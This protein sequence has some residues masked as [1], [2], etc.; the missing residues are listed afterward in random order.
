MDGRIGMM[1]GGWFVSEK[2][3]GDKYS[4]ELGSN[5]S[6]LKTSTQLVLDNDRG[7]LS[8]QSKFEGR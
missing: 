2:Q 5:G 4:R 1:G 7:G 3:F 8:A 6:V